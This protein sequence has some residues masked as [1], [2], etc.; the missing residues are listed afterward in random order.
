M[1]LEATAG[2]AF[3]FNTST[4]AI[5]SISVTKTMGEF[6]ATS[7]DIKPPSGSGGQSTPAVFRY[8]AGGLKTVEAKIDW[9]GNSVPEMDKV[10]DIWIGSTSNSGGSTVVD[11][12][13]E[14]TA[15]GSSLK[16]IASDVSITAQAGELIKGS[17]TFTFTKD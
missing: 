6:D 13:G 17:A 16:A 10:C 11:I 9:I 15:A 12:T 4:Y 8:R 3:K 7:M 1:A 2:I 5:T 14:Y